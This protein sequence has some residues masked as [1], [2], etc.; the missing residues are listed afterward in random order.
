MPVL[1][2][3]L[4]VERD[5]EG[6]QKVKHTFYKKEVASKY[7]ILKRSALSWRTKKSTLLQEAI[8]RISYV[9]LDL[10]WNETARHLSEYSHMLYL[11]GYSKK[12]RYHNIKGAI[13]RVE[14]M[15]TEVEA[16]TRESMYRTRD[17][18]KEAK[19]TKGGLS[20]ATWFL[21]SSVSCTVS[22]QP[23]PE[24][25]L[26]SQLQARITTT[27]RGDRRQVIEEGGEPVSMGLKKKNPFFK[28]GC[29]FGDQNCLV[30]PDK[31]CSNMNKVYIIRCLTCRQNLDPTIREKPSEP[32]GVRTA[33]Y[34][35][36][37]ACSV[38][39]RMLSH[40]EGHRRKDKDNPL[41]NH[42]I[43]QHGGEVQQY[44]ADIVGGDRGLLHLSLREALLIEG[45][46]PSQSL[47]S[48]MEQGRGKLIR[49]QAVR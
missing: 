9:S 8:R 7:T 33:H 24:S 14:T 10:P 21:T 4:W 25:K 11:S 37:T 40:R 42:D 17:Q 18:I 16:G 39:N 15:R 3:K 30:R 48:K 32:G 35:G 26:A 1:D 12:E 31:D 29:S 27:S 47:N 45:Q 44:Q 20:S 22:C 5:S 23:T 13:N 36:M 46:D 6:R 28:P 41:H 38:H 34:L 19:I 2:L 43:E 49:I